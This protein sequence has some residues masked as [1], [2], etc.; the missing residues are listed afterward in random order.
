MHGSEKRI[1]DLPIESMLQNVHDDSGIEVNS[2]RV[3]LFLVHSLVLSF[4]ARSRSLSRLFCQYIHSLI[5]GM[6][7]FGYFVCVHQK[8][9]NV[10]CMV[11]I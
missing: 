9:V 2:S 6:M 7:L 4:L 1:N 5:N 8:M 3:I 10:K 11:E